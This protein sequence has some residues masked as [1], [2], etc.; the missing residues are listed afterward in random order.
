MQLI[1]GLRRVT[2]LHRTKRLSEHL[3]YLAAFSP[4][5]FQ[6]TESNIFCD[7]QSQNPLDVH[8]INERLLLV[9]EKQENFRGDF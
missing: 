5:L 3:T 7:W 8:A 1:L 2:L 6:S 4:R 9:C